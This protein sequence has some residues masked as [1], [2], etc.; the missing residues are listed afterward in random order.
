MSS[1]PA[2]LSRLNDIVLSAPPPWWP[3]APG[4]YVLAAVLLL[5]MSGSLYRFWLTYRR[6]RYR[7]AALAELVQIEAQ[8]DKHTAGLLIAILKRAALHVWPRERVAALSGEQWRI[9]LDQHCAS[10]PFRGEAGDLLT[11]LAYH[12]IDYENSDLQPLFNRARI[13][14]KH[15]RAELC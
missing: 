14:I 6:N 1:D 11:G 9:F 7:R 8:Q 10:E 12:S 13:W 5:V 2:S 4:W 3:P 15:H